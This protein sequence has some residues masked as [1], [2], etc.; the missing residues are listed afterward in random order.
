MS[1]GSSIRALT[2]LSHDDGAG[3]V[4]GVVQRRVLAE[5]QGGHQDDRDETRQV[6]IS[7][8]AAGNFHRNCQRRKVFDQDDDEVEDEANVREGRGRVEGEAVVALI[9]LKPVDAFVVQR[10]QDV[11]GFLVAAVRLEPDGF[12]VK[13]GEDFVGQAAVGAV[14]DRPQRGVGELLLVREELFVA[15]QHVRQLGLH[16]MALKNKFKIIKIVYRDRDTPFYL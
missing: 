15:L 16:D 9:V 7:L 13:A 1:I 10:L 11:D 3:E 12:G 6:N 14:K 5:G 2:N 8:L 4:D